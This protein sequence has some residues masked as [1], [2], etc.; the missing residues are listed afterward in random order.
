M[1]SPPLPGIDCPQ[2]T[3]SGA[4]DERAALRRQIELLSADEVPVD[5]YSTLLP[6]PAL[7]AIQEEIQKWLGEPPIRVENLKHAVLNLP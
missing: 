6:M 1:K 4:V 3:L 2:I 7:Q 5:E